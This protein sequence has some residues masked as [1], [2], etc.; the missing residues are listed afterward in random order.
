MGSYERMLWRPETYA[1]KEATATD[2]HGSWKKHKFRQN[3]EQSGQDHQ[4]ATRSA[5][6]CI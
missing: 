4:Y 2:G 5:K 1:H 6:T 3:F